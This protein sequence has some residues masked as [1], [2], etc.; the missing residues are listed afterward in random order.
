M[1]LANPFFDS[2]F[3][4]MMDNDELSKLFISNI[5]ELPVTKIEKLPVVLA[6]ENISISEYVCHLD[7]VIETSDGNILV[8]IMKAHTPQQFLKY[9]LKLGESYALALLNGEI[10]DRYLNSS[11]TVK[12]IYLIRNYT[13]SLNQTISVMENKIE[14]TNATESESPSIEHKSYFVKLTGYQE[15]MNDLE[16]FLSLFDVSESEI[17]IETEVYPDQYKPILDFLAE[18]ATDA[19]LCANLEAKNHEILN[20][21]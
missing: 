12:T 15:P 1:K 11:N 5:V 9:R 6:S 10:K 14:K 13:N 17:I 20:R 4:L 2:V 3:E 18:I 19:E 16:R 7:F 8:E 21:N